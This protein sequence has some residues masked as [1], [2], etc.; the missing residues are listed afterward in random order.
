[1]NAS[2]KIKNGVQQSIFPT[3]F[4]CCCVIACLLAG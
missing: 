1:M 4:F 2:T 3:T